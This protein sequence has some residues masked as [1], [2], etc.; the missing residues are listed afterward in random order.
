MVK[1]TH[2]VATDALATLGTIIDESAG[3]DAIHLAVEPVVAVERLYPGQHVGFVEGGVGT[4]GKHVGIVD[5]FISGFVAE[6]QKFWLVVYPRTIT[7]LRHVWEHPSFQ[8]AEHAPPTT[9]AESSKDISVKWMTNWAV[10]HMSVDYYGDYDTPRSPE[11]ALGSAIDAGHNMNIGPYEDSRDYID[12]EWWD[13]WET[14]TG[15]RGNRGE[16]FSCAC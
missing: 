9:A 11:S 16:Y 3:R 13:H 12:N 15:E 6:G 7:S 5:P 8:T 1:Q 14:I 4:K 2:T 10:K